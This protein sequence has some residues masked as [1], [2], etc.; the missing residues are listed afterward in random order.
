MAEGWELKTD[1]RKGK[2]K[3]NHGDHGENMEYTETRQK[4]F[5]LK[6]KNIKVTA[7]N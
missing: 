1:N 5:S 3:C 6:R 2:E 7:E 4:G